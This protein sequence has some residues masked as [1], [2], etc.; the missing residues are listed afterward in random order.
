MS[1]D[2]D[3]FSRHNLDTSS[4][5]NL[6][7]DLSNLFNVNV[8]YGFFEYDDY[9]KY[10]PS[11]YKKGFN[12]LGVINSNN[13]D[14][15]IPLTVEDYLPKIIYNEIGDKIFDISEIWIDYG[16]DYPFSPKLKNH[17]IKSVF[18]TNDCPY[19]F[20]LLD[21]ENEYNYRSVSYEE[22][23]IPQIEIQKDYLTLSL[24]WLTTWNGITYMVSNKYENGREHL[25]EYRIK[26]RDY[27]GLLGEVESCIYT[28]LGIYILEFEYYEEFIQNIFKKENAPIYTFSELFTNKE[29]FLKFQKNINN[30]IL[31]DVYIDDFKDLENN[32]RF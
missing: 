24:D 28:S 20:N 12:I 21:F 1:K 2:L 4:I 26:H 6:A 5:E 15:T 8:V 31:P 9:W 17:L 22:T 14:L 19:E 16:L 27:M 32:T 10:D 29:S 30:G 18:K 3:I 23:N 25:N 11:K 13:S 7:I